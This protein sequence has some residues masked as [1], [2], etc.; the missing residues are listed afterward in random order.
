MGKVT[1]VISGLPGN[2]AT[3]V[4]NAVEQSEEFHLLD[5]GLTGPDIEELTS[6]EI[7]DRKIRLCPPTRRL[8]LHQYIS[9]AREQ[10]KLGPIL[11]ADFSDPN[12]VNENAQFYC[13]YGMPFVM[14]T[15]GGDRELLKQTVEASS[16]SAVIAPNMAAQV[17]ALQAAIEYMA[18]TFPD[19]FSDFDLISLDE[20][21]QFWITNNINGRM[22]Y[23]LGTMKAI[24]FLAKQVE[25][26]VRGKVFSMIDVLKG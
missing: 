22:P 26:G 7:G 12:A 23:V 17:V 8:M 20:T 2:M 11:I 3:L 9:Y 4:A 13:R 5:A 15:T 1:V 19:A 24:S 21:M 14:G 18:E 25:A 16:V 10:Q 6:V